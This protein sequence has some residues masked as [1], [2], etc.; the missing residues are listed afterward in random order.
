MRRKIK[1]V[2]FDLDGTLLDTESL[3]DKAI[4]KAFGES[5]PVEIQEER[6]QAGDLLPWEIKKQIVGKRGDE[7]IPMIIAYAQQHWGVGTK[8]SPRDLVSSPSVYVR[9]FVSPSSDNC[10]HPQIR[11]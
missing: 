7:W 8:E 6:R 10:R 2:L 3:S 1:A 11:R 4:L 9:L 5:L